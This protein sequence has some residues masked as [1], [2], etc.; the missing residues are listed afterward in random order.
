M[1]KLTFGL[2]QTKR[3]GHLGG[4]RVVSREE[5][6]T[7]VKAAC[8]ARDPETGIVVIAR[9]DSLA[10]HEWVLFSLSHFTEFLRILG[11]PQILLPTPIY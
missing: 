3:C 5:W 6:E 7:R 10:T 9:T 1:E 11:Y 2:V 4:K 8:Q